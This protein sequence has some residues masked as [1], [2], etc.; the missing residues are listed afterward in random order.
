MLASYYKIL[1]V[2]NPFSKNQFDIKVL[3]VIANFIR[4]RL[5]LFCSFGEAGV[6]N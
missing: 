4:D 5:F 6:E 1:K 2:W 3:Y